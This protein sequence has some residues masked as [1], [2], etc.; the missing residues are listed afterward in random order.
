M[1]TKTFLLRREH[2][3]ARMEDGRSQTSTGWLRF[4]STLFGTGLGIVMG[5]Q[6]SSWVD[7]L[8]HN[9]AKKWLFRPILGF[10]SRMGLTKYI[11]ADLFADLLSD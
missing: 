7:R 8:S 5:V 6:R 10:A 4:G 11:S 2:L 9:L 1:D 3:Q